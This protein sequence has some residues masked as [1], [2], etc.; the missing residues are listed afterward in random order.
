MVEGLCIY[1]KEGIVTKRLIDLEEENSE[2]ISL[3]I[4]SS[5]IKWCI[6]FAYRPAHNNNKDTI[7][8]ELPDS[9]NQITTNYHN[10][11]IV[12]TEISNL[13]ST[14]IQDIRG[15]FCHFSRTE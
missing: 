6:V 8:S 13:N 5:K 3:E 4:A 12:T 10:F 7:F 14:T 15:Y 9:L 1:I 11:I 2:T